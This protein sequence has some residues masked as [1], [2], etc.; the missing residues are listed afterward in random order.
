MIKVTMPG[1][2]YDGA[3]PSLSPE[4]TQLR[5]DLRGHVETLAGTIGEC[6]LHPFAVFRSSR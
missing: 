2:S 4:Q 6:N 5:D 3:L 1:K